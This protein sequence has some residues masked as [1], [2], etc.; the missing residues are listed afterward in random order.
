MSKRYVVFSKRMEG[1]ITRAESPS[2]IEMVF[3]KKIE[4]AEIFLTRHEAGEAVDEIRTFLET[5]KNNE[6]IIP[7]NVKISPWVKIHRRNI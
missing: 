7:V 6:A 4:D 5:E 2:A 3:T 1:Y